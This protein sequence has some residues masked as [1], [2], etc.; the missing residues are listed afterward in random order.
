MLMAKISNAGQFR[1]RMNASWSRFT[2][3][4]NALGKVVGSFEQ[5]SVLAGKGVVQLEETAAGNIPM[6]AMGFYR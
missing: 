4:A 5:R 2:Q 6:R 1:Q 3:R